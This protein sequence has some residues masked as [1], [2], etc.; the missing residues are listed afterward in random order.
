MGSY[1]EITPTSEKTYAMNPS[2][3]PYLEP[4]TILLGKFR[5]VE[6]LGTGGM[7]SVYR[8]DHLLMETQFALKCMNKF[9]EANASWRRFQNEAKASQMLDHPN[10]LKVFE[11]G[12]L[13]SGQPYFLMELIEGKTLADEIKSVTHL[14]IERAIHIFLQVAFA[15]GYA[16]QR[17]II[18]RDLKPSNIMLVPPKSE[19]EA[20]SIKVV[21][22]GIAKLIGVDE[23]N[24]QT[25]TRTG[26]IFGS[27]FYM[28]PEQCAGLPVDHRSDLYSIG[29]VFY[30][31]L[32]SAPPFIGEN[33]LSTMIKHQNDLQLSLREASLGVSYPAALEAII[34]KLLEKDPDKRYQSAKQLASDLMVLDRAI[35]DKDQ[36]ISAQ[37][38]FSLSVAP[39]K[40]VKAALAR[41]LKSMTLPKLAVFGFSMYCL[42]AASLYALMYSIKGEGIK[43]AIIET[44]TVE[45]QLNQDGSQ[46]WSQIEADK[47]HPSKM[48]KTF[49]FPDNK[50]IGLL[51]AANGSKALARGRVTAPQNMKTGLVA[52]EFISPEYIEKFRPEE[53]SVFDFNAKT[54]DSRCFEALRGFPDLRILNVSGTAFGDKDLAI[55]PSFKKL[56]YINFSHTDIDCVNLLKQPT[57]YNLNGIDLSHTSGCETFIKNISKFPRLYELT[58]SVNAFTDRDI[59]ELSKSKSLKM[60]DLSTNTI[61]D[62]GV[63]SLLP[64]KTLE[65]LDLSRTVVTPKVVDTL[66]KFPN[67]R[68]VE[69]GIR[70]W[71]QAVQD[72]FLRELRKSHPKMEVRFYDSYTHDPAC[73]PGFIWLGAGF[74][75][76]A[77]TNRLI[78]PPPTDSITER[79]RAPSQSSP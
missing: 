19:N 45:P 59:A 50:V 39:E 27:P 25:L 12:L 7:G 77:N 78:P 72:N 63:A 53:I 54:V 5:V 73:L 36:Q 51:V 1:Q 62:K 31:A 15:I 79:R 68:K 23:F 37:G 24:Q 41:M 3:G 8:V 52:G 43:P 64:V 76:H 11:L 67:L 49:Y 55:L 38:P 6:L 26:E 65:S 21:D 29:C 47:L 48:K 28:S 46:Y 34:N 74:A 35:H 33:A 17:K 2:A 20:E 22:F 44:P 58:V 61:S 18:H 75:G 9:Q 71:P 60:L 40:G 14:P 13:E 56:Q 30:E 66:K 42:G 70:E 4:G 16:H 69:L 57:V 32:T 10:L